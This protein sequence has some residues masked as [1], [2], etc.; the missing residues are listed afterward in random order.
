MWFLKT[1]KAGELG[2]SYHI[3]IGPRP[4]SVSHR[5]QLPACDAVTNEKSR[6]PSV[7]A[8]EGHSGELSKFDSN[9][10]KSNCIGWSLMKNVR[11]QAGG[12]PAKYIIMKLINYRTNEIKRVDAVI[13]VRFNCFD[14]APTF[15]THSPKLTKHLPGGLPKKAT[16][17]EHPVVHMLC[18]AMYCYVSFL[19]RI[20]FSFSPSVWWK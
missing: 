14:I 12:I 3:V 7:A 19:G 17:L 10:L 9:L 4:L 1:L 2:L 20:T 8:V 6:W 5:P 16:H 13:D 11:L 18:I 15:C